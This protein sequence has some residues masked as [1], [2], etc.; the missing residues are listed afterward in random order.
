MI[1]YISTSLV[2]SKYRHHPT[3]SKGMAVKLADPGGDDMTRMP[4]PSEKRWPSELSRIPNPYAPVRKRAPFSK[5]AVIGF[6]ISCIGLF[7]FAM[8]G[9]FGTA[10]SGLG[11]R[12]AK[13]N[14]LR[15]R[16]FAIA[17]MILGGVDFAFYLSAHFLWK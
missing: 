15:G 11:L 1:A 16:S 7:V 5:A 8:A 3:N 2:T 9:P 13:E 4:Q 10:I 6:F 14:G 17:G 12:R